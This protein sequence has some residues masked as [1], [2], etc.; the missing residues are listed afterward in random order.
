MSGHG[1]CL[2]MRRCV[3]MYQ[4]RMHVSALNNT[5]LQIIKLQLK[6]DQGT[7]YID[8][9]NDNINHEQMKPPPDNDVTIYKL[10][11]HDPLRVSV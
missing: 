9:R 11:L 3:C 8:N 5:K 10:V 7:M 2:T 6:E 4:M 1:L